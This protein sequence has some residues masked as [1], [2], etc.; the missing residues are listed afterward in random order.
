ME[1]VGNDEVEVETGIV[2]GTVDDCTRVVCVVVFNNAFAVVEGSMLDEAL[3]DEEI[4]V[5]NVLGTAATFAIVCVDE[6]VTEP[7]ALFE[8][9]LVYEHGNTS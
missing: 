1:G 4:T 8:N 3:F 6:G 7:V 9:I 2:D 5:R